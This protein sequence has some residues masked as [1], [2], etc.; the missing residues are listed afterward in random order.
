MLMIASTS[1]NW[2]CTE[3]YLFVG[4]LSIHFCLIFHIADELLKENTELKEQRLCKIC[5]THE[6]NM[7]FLPCGHLVS[8]ASCAPAL[9]LC[10]ICRAT[11]KGSI[12]TYI[13]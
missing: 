2:M 1:Q 11:I 3:Y 7:V 6:A 5:M 9:T 4:L 10:P 8:C 13:V 12:R